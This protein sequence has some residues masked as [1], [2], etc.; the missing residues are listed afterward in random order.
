MLGPS[1]F[2]MPDTSGSIDSNSPELE[3][4]H[5]SA[6]GFNELY[7]GCKN[8]RFFVY[9]ALKKEFRGNPLYEELL[10]K[11]FNIGFSLSHSGICQYFGMIDFPTI[12]NCIIMEWIDGSTLENLIRSGQIDKPLARKII[13]DIC[14]ALEYIHRKQ[15]IHRD[16]K[17]ENIMVTNN[18]RNVKI[19]DFGLSDADSYNIL[20]APAGTKFYASPELI[21][22]EQIDSRSDLWSLGLII[23]ELSRSYGHIASRCLQRDK[24]KRFASA[25]EI[26]KAVENTSARRIRNLVL[27]FSLITVAVCAVWAVTNG[28]NTDQEIPAPVA[29]VPEDSTTA[30]KRAEPAKDTVTMVNVPE[31]EVKEKTPKASPHN[32]GANLDASD[33]DDLFNDAAELI[34]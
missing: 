10:R 32:S 16:L 19:I 5:T 6:D 25:D 22:G 18:G 17:P 34:L 20:K 1:G 23:K 33:L 14:D 29:A 31:T 2:F 12:G 8:G 15:I 21:A 3:L 4:I 28:R 24:D 27:I 30:A 13:C 7:R 26:R 9:K 11:D